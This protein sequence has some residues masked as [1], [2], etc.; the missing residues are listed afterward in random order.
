MVSPA[1]DIPGRRGSPNYIAK[2]A[3]LQADITE[4]V[5]AVLA[6]AQL[7]MTTQGMAQSTKALL[8]GAA[9]IMMF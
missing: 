4:L 1:R 9:F 6:S 3:P 2:P 8:W 7:H 5:I